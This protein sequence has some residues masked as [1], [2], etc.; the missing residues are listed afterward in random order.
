MPPATAFAPG[1]LGSGM[2]MEPHVGTRLGSP[3]SCAEGL[4]LTFNL[5]RLLARAAASWAPGTRIAPLSECQGGRNKISCAGQ[6]G[7]P[8][9]PLSLGSRGWEGEAGPSGLL[10]KATAQVF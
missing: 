1:P 4:V 2:I 3:G 6:A 5:T 9:C 10:E 7:P 8:R